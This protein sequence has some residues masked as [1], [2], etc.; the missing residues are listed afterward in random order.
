MRND[1]LKPLIIRNEGLGIG[2][3]S[4]F[5]LVCIG[6]YGMLR[7]DNFRAFHIF[8]LILI[9]LGF[10]VLYDTFKKSRDKSPKII[11]D[12]RGIE[13]CRDKLFF[14]WSKI[15]TANIITKRNR[16]RTAYLKI[17]DHSVNL[18]GL[19]YKQTEIIN[20]IYNF[21]GIICTRLVELGEDLVFEK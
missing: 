19:R 4:L 10:Y 16:D 11:I 3:L 13:I 8:F 21:S 14:D 1:F 20:T 6:S 5:G 15:E 2:W 17:N 7:V 9:I 18:T 12:R